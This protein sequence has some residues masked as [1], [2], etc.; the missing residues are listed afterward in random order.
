MCVWREGEGRGG[1]RRERE[2]ERESMCVVVTT[3]H[4]S[5]SSVQFPDPQSRYLSN[6]VTVN[7][8][9]DAIFNARD[10]LMVSFL[11]PPHP[12]PSPYFSHDYRVASLWC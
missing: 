9:I 8:S 6:Q 7:G 12:E 5:I 11:H 4:I 2:R 1:G 3:I 10:Q